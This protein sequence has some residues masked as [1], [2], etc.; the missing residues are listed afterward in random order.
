[1]NYQPAMTRMLASIL[2][3]VVLSL[4]CVACGNIMALLVPM[5]PPH[6]LM[7]GCLLTLK[8]TYIITLVD[9]SVARLCRVSGGVHFTLEH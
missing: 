3:F 7:L 2:M 1:M 6:D 4:K 8:L 5:L 9:F